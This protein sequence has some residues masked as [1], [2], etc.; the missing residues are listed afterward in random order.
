MQT[1][2]LQQDMELPPEAD[3]GHE[4]SWSASIV[5]M[6][7]CMLSTGLLIVASGLEAT[8]TGVGTHSQL[9]LAP[10]GF[11]DHTGM[12]CATCGMT[13]SFALASDGH[14]IDAFINQPAGALL[15][16]IT[17]IVALLS[18]YAAIKGLN[19]LPMMLAIW[20]PSTLFIL[21][22]IVVGSWAYKI[23]IMQA[24]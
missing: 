16:L 13:T 10:C 3:N 5:A 22:G 23:M 2:E 18:G 14:L 19:L 4:F 17:A 20:K 7:V 9:G 21:G 1:T 6:L 24:G 11:L 8:S 12:P 15:A